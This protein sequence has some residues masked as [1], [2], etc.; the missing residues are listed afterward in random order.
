MIGG[1]RATTAPSRASLVLATHLLRLEARHRTPG[2]AAQNSSDAV[3]VCAK[4]RHVI[5]AFASSSGFRSLLVRAVTL[6]K[7][8][9][10]AL[11]V[12]HVHEDGSLSG[13]DTMSPA[14]GEPR[15]N[16]KS[17]G[18][19]GKM[20]DSQTR[21]SGAGRSGGELLVAC[22]LDLLITFIGESLTLQLVR[23]AWPDVPA[24][25]PRSGT[26]ERHL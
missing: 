14:S 18:D 12:L 20:Q 21:R 16:D 13:F 1:S 15:S 23:S 6:A 3:T 7:S 9:D 5:T 24:D 26:E 25:A 22:L 17:S 10:S 11:A 8:Q 19:T 4:L 2:S